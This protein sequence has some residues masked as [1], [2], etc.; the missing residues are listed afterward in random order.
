MKKNEAFLV[1]T[2]EGTSIHRTNLGR[3]ILNARG[4][5]ALLL[6]PFVYV[7]I[8]NYVPIYGI[9]MAFKRFAP[10]TGVLGSPWVGLYNFQRFLGSPNFL[11]IIRNTLV[12]SI[13]G[14]V[15]GFPFPVIL[16]ICVNH[17]LRRRLKKFTQSVTFAP[18]FLS[19]V[20]MV[21]IITQI[22]GMRTGGVNVLLSTLGFE[23]TNFLA[24]NAL[25]SHI[26]IWS[27]IWQG[28]GSGAVIYISALAAV[29]PTLHEAAQID[30][31]TLWQRVWHIDLTTIRPII[32]IMLILSMGGILG[33]NLEK[34]YLMQNSLNIT[35]SEVI[36]TY[37][38]KVGI[39]SSRPDYS[40]GTAIGL[41][42]NVV[43]II[44]TLIVNKVANVLSGEGMF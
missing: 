37:V 15:A 25:F 26:Y 2:A 24:S 21:T 38:Y 12:L 22:F 5:Y 9:V 20:I 36:S 18:T 14:L 13:Y 28:T 23:E 3:R 8:F 41:F 42:Q 30:G 7:V 27:G 43:G 11:N 39:Q 4:L 33:S 31:A 40:L 1:S 19:A 16:A 34:I 10:R 32:V 44:L 6:V 35:V 29:D 17:S